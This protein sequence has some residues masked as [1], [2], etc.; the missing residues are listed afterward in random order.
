M[1]N[2]GE[3]II[4]LMEHLKAV[5]PAPIFEEHCLNALVSTDMAESVIV[6]LNRLEDVLSDQ[7]FFEIDHTIW[8]RASMLAYEG[9]RG[10]QMS[11]TERI[12]SGLGYGGYAKV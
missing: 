7:L 12:T 10:Y 4:A 5:L 8:N 1:D 3:A 6:M 11:L 2:L 9:T